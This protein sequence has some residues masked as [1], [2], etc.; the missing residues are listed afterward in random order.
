MIKLTIGNHSGY[1]YPTGLTAMAIDKL[2]VNPAI[3]FP[4]LPL[5][6]SGEGECSMYTLIK[7]V[8]A[9]QSCFFEHTQ[10]SPE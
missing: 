10:K 2:E 6:E 1:L 4:R 3:R 9:T 8:G 7:S 5:D